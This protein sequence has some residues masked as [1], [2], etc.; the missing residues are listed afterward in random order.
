MGYRCSPS[1][2]DPV[3]TVLYCLM[4]F[5]IRLALDKQNDIVNHIGIGYRDG[6]IFSRFEPRERFIALKHADGPNDVF[7]ADVHGVAARLQQ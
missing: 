4:E 3:G 7:Q 1:H 6:E 2:P 5:Q